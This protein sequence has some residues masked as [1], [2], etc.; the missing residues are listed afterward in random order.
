M[1]FVIFDAL[2][3]VP[4][5]YSFTSKLEASK[6]MKIARES[7]VV[8]GIL[9]LVFMLIGRIL[10]EA[11]K[12]SINDFKIAAGVV[13]FILSIELVLGR[14]EPGMRKVE[15]EEFAIVPLATPLLAGPG[16]ISMVIYLAE[17]VGPI[18]TLTSILLNV[19]LA[20]IIL[21]SSN[22]IFS[23]ISRNGARAITRI[24]GLII[25]AMAV[26]MIRSGLEGIMSHI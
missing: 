14:L 25:A 1:L 22:K 13:L 15:L 19:I 11:L 8:A 6:R 3:N 18:E 24:T 7:V 16:S 2:G 5:F 10:F 20:Y 9:L 21:S 12:V 23:I 17:A 4:L 26:A